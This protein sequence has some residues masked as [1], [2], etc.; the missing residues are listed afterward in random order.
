MTNWSS[1]FDPGKASGAILGQ[2]IAAIVV[3]VL[4]AVLGWVFGPVKWWWGNRKMRKLVRNRRF[5]FVFNPA[6]PSQQRKV[7]TFLPTGQIGEGQNNNE[8]SWRP[9]RGQV[10]IFGADGALYSRFRFDADTGRLVNTND[11]DI[12][13]IRG[14][15][16]E[17]MGQRAGQGEHT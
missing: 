15:Y 7:V 9:K 12:R 2:V 11:P 6:N 16:F 14:Q 17:V 8:H 10:E 5:I 13:S 3:I 1:W 4:L